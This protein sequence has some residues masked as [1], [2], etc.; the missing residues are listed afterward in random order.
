MQF[1]VYNV[2]CTINNCCK[3]QQKQNTIQQIISTKPFIDSS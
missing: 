2:E 1:T 3:K